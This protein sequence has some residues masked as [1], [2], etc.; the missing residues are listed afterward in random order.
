MSFA[1]QFLRKMIKLSECPLVDETS[2]KEIEAMLSKEGDWKE[3][4]L[5]ELFEEISDY[6]FSDI[7][8]QLGAEAEGDEL[9]INYMGRKIPL[10]H[11][12]VREDLDILDKLLIL[13]YVKRAGKSTLTGKWVA[14]RELKD[15]IVRAESFNG[16]CELAIA[17]MFERDS[18]GLL[19]K[20]NI[21]GAQKVSGY[22]A[23]HSFV[24]Y[25]LPKVPFL[26]LL[27][28]GD[29]EFG[30]ECKILFDSTADEYLDVETLLY[31]GIALVRVL[32]SG[33]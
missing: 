8:D 15:G 1:V 33:H 19:D 21:V 13:I 14:F 31:L 24:V 11:T 27:W 25:P 16:A 9:N 29:E 18:H 23:P 2:K 32:G 3:R 28:P 10:S 30:A 20:M 22:S 26:L 4:R 17:G 6:D 5:D 12:K 7:A